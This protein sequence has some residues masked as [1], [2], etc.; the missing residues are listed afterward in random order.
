MSAKIPGS[1]PNRSKKMRYGSRN[2]SAT[3]ARIRCACRIVRE[4]LRER[5][6]GTSGGEEIGEIIRTSWSDRFHLAVVDGILILPGNGVHRQCGI[7]NGTLHQTG[8]SK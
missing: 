3:N 4:S 8:T 6:A 1:K 5:F 2:R 7:M